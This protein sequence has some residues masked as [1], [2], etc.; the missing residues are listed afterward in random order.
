M[1]IEFTVGNFRS[2]GEEV[3][4]SLV[5]AALHSQDARLDAD[6]LVPLDRH[7]SVLKSAV[8]YG[9]NASG[10]SNLAQALRFMGD[11][12][13]HSA[14]GQRGDA[15]EVEPFRLHADLREEPSSFEVV[16]QVAGG[17]YRYGFETDARAVQR[18]WLYFL[19][20]APESEKARRREVMLFDRGPE[21]FEVR[22]TMKTL[23]E[24]KGM[25]RDN[26]L[27]LSVAAQF[28]SEHAT[29]VLDWFRSVEHLGG[30]HDESLAWTAA[31]MAEDAGFA[32]AV[33]ELVRSLDVGIQDIEVA[34]E[35]EHL[36]PAERRVSFVGELEIRTTH[37]VLDH[38]DQPVGVEQFKL[39]SQE[40]GGTRKLFALAGPLLR[41]LREGLVL[42]IDEFDARLHPLLSQAILG[43]F[44]DPATNPKGAQLVA[45]THD[46]HLLDRRRLRRDQIWFVEKDGRGQ[47][48]LYSLATLKER[49]DAAF[50][51]Q[52]LHGR[53]GAVPLP[54]PLAAVI[55]ESAS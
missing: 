55:A 53:Y 13:V 32:R 7:L 49:N 33:V 25:T 11:F 31:R 4:F 5:A 37:A 22:P 3:T 27:F 18:E 50:E 9:A 19:K 21:Q 15:I 14:R 28:N 8:I 46:T 41:A 12:V 24:L 34:V 35:V 38:E 40:S 45:L 36:A 17:R 52:Y 43:L 47:S 29:A 51:Q 39:E 26:A 1:L 44:N 30:V 6:N 2:F 10:K 16:F 48:R 23:A 54:G 20:P 42:V